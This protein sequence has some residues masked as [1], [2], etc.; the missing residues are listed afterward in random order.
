MTNE[1]IAAIAMLKLANNGVTMAQSVNKIHKAAIIE[2]I[3]AGIVEKTTSF[4]Y[5]FGAVPAYKLA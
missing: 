3:D 4:M 2:L 1:Q 5:G